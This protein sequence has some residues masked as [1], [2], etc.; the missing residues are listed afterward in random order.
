[1]R[2]TH[3]L[4]CLLMPAAVA[5]AVSPVQ[6]VAPYLDGAF[7]AVA[8]GSSTGFTT[9]NAFPNLQ[10]IGPLW[11]TPY[12]GT[13]ELV[14]VGKAGH[15]WRFENRPDVMPSEVTVMLNLS[16]YGTGVD[17]PADVLPDADHQPAVVGPGSVANA[18]DMAFHQL[19][20]HPDFGVP[21]A[22]AEHQVFACYSHLPSLP[23]ADDAHTY[24][25]VSRFTVVDDP[26]E[27]P[28]LDPDSEL[29]LIDQFDA[30]RNHQGG[31]MFFGDDG[32]LY[33]TTGDGGYG[34]GYETAANTPSQ[35][36][37]GA[38]M[39]GIL[40]I[41]VDMRGGSISH[42]IRRHPDD[43]ALDPS[44]RPP[45]G[46]PASFS[47]NYYIP[48]DNPWVDPSPSSDVLEEFWAIGLR[49]PHTM[50]R[51]PATGQ[52]WIGEV[53]GS[54]EEIHLAHAG[55][56]FQWR[57]TNGG[58]TPK[59]NPLIGVDAPAILTIPR[60]VGTC[61]IGGFVY[62]GSEFPTL[63]GKL[64]Y[65]DHV[66][67]TVSSLG[68]T[69][70]EAP[71]VDFL[72]NFSRIGLKAGLGNFCQGPNGEV[73]MPDLGGFDDA[74]DIE[75][76]DGTIQRLAATAVTPD[77]PGLLSATGAFSDLA[78]LT[79]HTAFLPYEPRSQLWSDR[80]VKQRWI[81]LPNDGTHNSTAEQI[82]F[83]EDD[84]WTFPPGTVLMKHFELPVDDGNPLVTVR[85]E[86]RFIVCTEGGGKY[87]VTYRWLP[88]QSDAVLL[89]AS[90][91]G[92][93][94]VAEEGGG[95]RIETWTYP[96]RSDC[97]QCHN[98]ASGQALGLVTHA[99]NHPFPYP[100]QPSPVNQ[101]RM[102]SERGMLDR[103][104]TAEEIE[105]FIRS[106]SLDETDVP[107]AHRAR[108]YLDMN[109]SHCHQP[110]APGDGFDA[111]LSVPLL[112]Q[113]LINGIPQGYPLLGPDSRYV[114]PTDVAAS[115]VH[116][117]MD[118]SLP[119]TA[120]M[121]PLSKNL[122]DT[123]AVQ[124]IEGWIQSLD[125]ADY[126][127]TPVHLHPVLGGPTTT[128]GDFVATLVFEDKVL[129]FNIGDLA[130]TNGI[131]LRSGG[132]GDVHRVTIRPTADPVTVQ[133]PA[134]SVT[135]ANVGISNEA[136][137]LL[138]VSFSDSE[139]PVPAFSGVPLDGIIHGTL[140]LGLDFGKIVT[141]LS[142]D[143][144]V[145]TNGSVDNLLEVNGVFSFDLT[146]GGIGEV[147]IDLIA[148]AVID[149]LGR[150]NAAETVILFSPAPSLGPPELAYTTGLDVWLDASDI[151]GLGNTTLDDGDPVATWLNKGTTSVT[152][153][154]A[155]S[156][157]GGGGTNGIFIADGGNGAQDAVQLANTR[158]QFGTGSAADE[159]GDS[160]AVTMYFVVWQAASSGANASLLTDYGNPT[161]KLRNLR[162]G[163]GSVGAYLRDS[164]NQTV[165]VGHGANDLA[166]E[167]WAVLFYSFDPATK[168]ATWGELGNTATAT[169]AA[170]DPTTTFEAFSGGPVT[171][172]GFHDGN[173]GFDFNGY[174]SEVLI[175]DHLLNADQRAEVEGYLAGKASNT[176]GDADAD[177]IPDAYELANTNPPSSTALDPLLDDD[178][179]GLNNL[180][181][182]LGLDAAYQ[183]HGFGQTL[184]NAFDSDG[185]GY[186]DGFEAATGSNLND[187]GSI[188]AQP[189]GVA[190]RID[191]QRLGATGQEIQPGWAVWEIDKFAL[192]KTVN[193][194]SGDVTLTL[195]AG[196]AG[197]YFTSRGGPG[198]NR[199]GDIT[200]TSFNEVVEDFIVARD[201]DGTVLLSF[202]GL[203]P[204]AAYVLSSYHNDPYDYSNNPGFA[205]G[206]PSI[207]PVV[208]TGAQVG[209]PTDGRIT[210]IRPGNRTDSDFFNSVV[211]F[212]ADGSGHSTVELA[213]TNS[214][215][216]LSGLSLTDYGPIAPLR[217]TSI[218]FNAN[219]E[220]ELVVDGLDLGRSYILKRS[221]NLADGFPFTV[222]GPW[223]P[224]TPA[225]LL[226][227]PSPPP[228]E[229]FYRVEEAP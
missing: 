188:P 202:E 31:A 65:G 38:L 77:P 148:D 18:P 212:T 4:V 175:Y 37:D 204:G 80:A 22:A 215:V 192:P 141:G 42:P 199:D 173:N 177:G 154:F 93:F 225:E 155:A 138:S 11:G 106:A 115:L 87:G 104:L 168:T 34:N 24:F 206:D 96:G 145:V 36:I 211:S 127:A 146:P 14:V 218:G 27:G 46:W 71:D 91:T 112:S 17:L 62:R 221:A 216:V 135:G 203:I 86:T 41:D 19:I 101:L 15:V 123:A 57:Y 43:L 172:F 207:T 29:I 158:Y 89:N 99:L 201:G 49:S 134:D 208:T 226:I 3:W 147:R 9:V 185:D 142:L 217:I 88:D 74:T 223:T 44:V 72:C 73:F 196:G 133:L 60:S 79:P 166:S 55:D 170:F 54:A 209:L 171:L 149:G 83:S 78:T 222:L 169:N 20:F 200:G 130:V 191:F 105:G 165:V 35:R 183:A 108:S 68:Y 187:P 151:D 193:R 164:A 119:D 156:S 124:A 178:N 174:V 162:A 176:E 25:R 12:P 56:N 98:E 186:G 213:S 2:L 182:Y 131:A 107:V 53:G 136:S 210:N 109:C 40:R 6:P 220:I 30:N 13:D 111:R 84:P 117:R 214:F 157:G 144:F 64:L 23:G 75:D 95:T 16:K 32:F 153:A 81:A 152:N 194:T 10:F 100:D 167:E 163:G 7:P 102:F 128:T 150:G 66:R 129:D 219:D 76:N 58:G 26:V 143:D 184:A 159:W 161:A 94:T 116:F 229:A 103:T 198:D 5:V 195:T 21:G 85:L 97:F 197:G 189:A 118:H 61:V 59:P 181:E 121:P 132:N 67:G 125:P 48:S 180:Q 120:A 90:E 224:A 137:N 39:G 140:A 139:P 63:V 179:D 113:N 52:I 8:P 114:K 227:D 45:A 69:P 126:P 70:G 50:Q 33:I 205:T 47:G 51:D 82:V 122:V 28:V 160:S 92:N 228:G 1:M 190:M 110:G